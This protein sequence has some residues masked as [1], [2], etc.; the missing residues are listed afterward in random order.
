MTYRCLDV[1]DCRTN[2]APVGKGGEPTGELKKAMEASF[3]SVETFK[4]EFS[5]MTAG[6]QGS[7][8]GWLGYCPK[9]KSLKM[10]TCTNQDPLSTVGLV[11]LLGIDVWEHAYYLQYQNVRPNYLKEIWKVVNWHN[12]Q[13]RFEN[14]IKN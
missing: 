9:S 8:W 6:V 14:A 10:T 5:T 1:M 11:P 4:S 2:L 12:V 3:G 7:G 13:E